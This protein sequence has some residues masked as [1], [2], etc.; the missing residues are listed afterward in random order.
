MN[1]LGFNASELKIL[2]RL[3]TPRKIQDF[4]ETIPINFKEGTLMSPRRVLREHR[5]HCVEGALLAAATLWLRGEPPLLLDLKSV[6]RDF[7]HVV[8]LFK[9]NGRWGAISKTNHAVLRYREPVYKNVRELAMSHFHE[10]FLDDGKKTMRSFSRAFDLRKFK[11]DNWLTSEKELWLIE[12]A[13]DAAP[14]EQI[15]NKT[16]IKELR[17]AD[18]I[19]IK[20]GKVSEWKKPKT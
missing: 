14:H 7:D 4:L 19:E 5:A 11:R 2:R 18:P 10:Y 12:H 13:L 9:R 20:V 17:K 15:L 3:D 1:D 8:A 16:M 6:E